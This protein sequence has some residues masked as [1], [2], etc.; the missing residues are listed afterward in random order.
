MVLVTEYQQ[1]CSEAS[2]IVPPR[3][4]V[5]PANIF[6]AITNLLQNGKT[7][8]QY[9]DLFEI[10]YRDGTQILVAKNY[11]GTIAF[12]DGG[13]LEILP[14]TA[15]EDEKISRALFL[16]MLRVVYNV[17]YINT[18]LSQLNIE[19]NPPFEIFIMMFLEE[20]SK[21]NAIGYRCVYNEVCDNCTSL[22]GRI[23]FPNHI[24]NNIVHQEKFFVK[25]EEYNLNC[26]ENRIIKATLQFLSEISMSFENRMRINALLPA[27]D[28]IPP[29]TNPDN[30]FQSIQSE[31]G[32]GHYRV[33]LQWCRFF[34]NNTTFT[35]F[36]GENVAYSYLFKMDGLFELY[37]GKLVKKS[38]ET[39][40]KGFRVFLQ[41]ELSLFDKGC[42]TNFTIRP[43]IYIHNDVTNETYI[44]DTK[45]KMVREKG[46][47][48]E[49]MY[50][51]FAYSCRCSTIQTSLVYPKISNE[52][53]GEWNNSKNYVSI[54]SHFVDLLSD[55]AIDNLVDSIFSE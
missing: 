27:F 36:A 44:V 37:I 39:R 22:R 53:S 43:D 32:T 14:K 15:R 41:H 2:T 45:W 16:K 55:D 23:D 25:Y 26:P 48:I 29:S 17:P 5:I 18:G 12:K 1:L 34:L 42:R 38:V 6:D 52:T 33:A 49:D 10:K 47:A 7:V 40:Y 35:T 46:Y 3:C 50:Q 19:K 8:E 54:K 13:I 11:V 4:K 28:S 21:L 9:R 24:K 51:M 30:D 20:I 31:R